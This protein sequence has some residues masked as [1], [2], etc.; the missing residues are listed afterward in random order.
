MIMTV[1]DARR[2][3]PKVY[4]ISIPNTCIIYMYI[5]IYIHTYTHTYIHT[6]IHTYMEP[7]VCLVCLVACQ[8]IGA[9]RVRVPDAR[10]DSNNN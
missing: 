1:Q 3:A 4:S 6:Y 5:Y 10:R 2:D 8:P 7:T 9:A